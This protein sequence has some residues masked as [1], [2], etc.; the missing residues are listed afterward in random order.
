[1]LVGKYV[2]GPILMRNARRRRTLDD[3]KNQ[4]VMEDALRNTRRLAPSRR[5]PVR[6][7]GRYSRH[8][9]GQVAAPAPEGRDFRYGAGL[10]GSGHSV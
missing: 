6:R 4:A 3:V 8:S 9:F 1:M 2:V 7:C 10:R 5:R